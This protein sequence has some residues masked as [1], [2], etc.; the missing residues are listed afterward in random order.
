MVERIAF[1]LQLLL[2]ASLTSVIVASP[3][4]IAS[5]ISSERRH[6]L[7]LRADLAS[8]SSGVFLGAVTFSIIE[9]SLKLGNIFSVALG[10]AIGT[11]TFS[12][13]RYRIQKM[14]N[15][16]GAYG[17]NVNTDLVNSGKEN[18][19]EANNN[20]HEVSKEKKGAGK[21]IIIGNIVDSHPENIIIGVIIALGL[22]GLL[23]WVLVLIIGNFAA[24][25]VGT[26]ELVG[27]GESKRQIMKKWTIAFIS[28]AIGGPIGYFFGLHV[29]KIF[30]SI[31][32]SFAAGAL[33]SFVTEELIPDAYRKV[34]WHIGISASLGL[35]L[36]FVLFEF[37]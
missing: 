15:E 6:S 22:P 34:N 21:L 10:F 13:I 35:F 25:I 5:L 28:V 9:E 32:F 11:V 1:D 24:T 17:N 23:P 37:L 27:E 3:F 14:P 36:S 8:F 31:I 12:I 29:D 19:S 20:D 2:L 33:V 4:L 30:S 26:R 7:R 18:G 16:K